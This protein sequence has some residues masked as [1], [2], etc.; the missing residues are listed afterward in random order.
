[1]SNFY[2]VV[3][4]ICGDDEDS[5]LT[6]CADSKEEAINQFRHWMWEQDGSSQEDRDLLEANGEGVFV[7]QILVSAS[8]ITS[9]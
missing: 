3:G 5:I 1:M 6:L 9:L 7:N 8:P 4:R 2:A